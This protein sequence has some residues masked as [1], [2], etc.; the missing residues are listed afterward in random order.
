MIDLTIDKTKFLPKVNLSGSAMTKIQF[1]FLSPLIHLLRRIAPDESLE[2][3]IKLTISF[4]LS[5][6]KYRRL[7]LVGVIS[8]C[9]FE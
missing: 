7:G 3:L 5:A 6:W 9:L 1:Q 2:L 8:S 4:T